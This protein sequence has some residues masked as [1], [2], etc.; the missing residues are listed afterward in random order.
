MTYF[1]D[2]SDY[3]YF[4]GTRQVGTKNVGWLEQ[5]HEFERTVPSEDTLDCL[6][7]FCAISV[8]QTRGIHA[9]D[10]CAP[11]QSVFAARHGIRLRLG[12]SEI[13]VF[14]KEGAVYAAPNLIYHYIRTH[15]YKPPD[16][17]LRAVSKGSRP[18]NQKYFERLK[19]LG[20]EWSM[21]P[22]PPVSQ[23][24]FKFVKVE[25]K[26]QRVEVQSSAY[27]DES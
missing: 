4:H 1:R 16:E 5:N 15:H 2:L 20:L 7:S 19:K 24:R 8:I 27:L 14:S 10:L 17:F 22:S 3:K 12:S 21:T 6:W 18:P 23:S 11:P 25:G 26:V 13:R 9:C